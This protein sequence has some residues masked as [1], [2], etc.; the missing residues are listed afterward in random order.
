MGCE[1]RSVNKSIEQ[2]FFDAIIQA[3]CPLW[4]RPPGQAK[5]KPTGFYKFLVRSTR[6][7]RAK[8]ENMDLEV[9]LLLLVVGFQLGEIFTYWFLTK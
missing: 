2:K 8:G 9:A 5:A 4:A 7:L 6:G 3:Q 1:N